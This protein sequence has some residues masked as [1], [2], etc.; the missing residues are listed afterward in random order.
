RHE[1]AFS[2]VIGWFIRAGQS[3]RRTQSRFDLI[4]LLSNRNESLFPLI[5]WFI[6]ASQSERRTCSRF[7][8]YKHKSNSY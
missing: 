4:E 7:N 2:V 5:G 3:Q 6:P 8:Y 1:S